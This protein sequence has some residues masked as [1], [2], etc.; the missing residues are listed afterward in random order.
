MLDFRKFFPHNNSNCLGMAY[1]LYEIVKDMPGVQWG[2]EA[3]G[4]IGIWLSQPEDSPDQRKVMLVSDTSGNGWVTFSGLKEEEFLIIPYR[5][6]QEDYFK[7]QISTFLKVMPMI[8]MENLR[9][10]EKVKNSNRYQLF[11]R[12]KNVSG[13]L[14]HNVNHNGFNINCDYFNFGKHDGPCLSVDYY[15][16]CHCKEDIKRAGFKVGDAIRLED[17]IYVGMPITGVGGAV[18]DHFKSASFITQPE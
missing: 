2:K 4:G 3:N 6:G 5:N 8:T 11:Y 17:V 12:T 7:N 15:F 1:Q 13:E 16:L 10:K 9:L 18:I 14:T